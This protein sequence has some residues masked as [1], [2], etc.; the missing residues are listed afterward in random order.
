MPGSWFLVIPRQGAAD[1]QATTGRT[2]APQAPPSTLSVRRTNR[3][4]LPG[5]R[6]VGRLRSVRRGAGEATGTVPGPGHRRLARR[7]RILRGPG[8][9]HGTAPSVLQAGRRWSRTVVD[10]L[11]QRTGF[12]RIRPKAQRR[13]Q[14]GAGSGGVAQEREVV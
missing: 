3:G 2:G 7:V 8:G 9:H 6:L 14:I 5:D 13:V 10:G 1:G 11:Q 12:G 4:G